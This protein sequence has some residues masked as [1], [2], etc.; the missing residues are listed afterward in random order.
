MASF[1]F[2][3]SFGSVDWKLIALGLVVVGILSALMFYNYG[4]VREMFQGGASENVFTMYYADWCPHC[5]DA[6][7]EFKK[8]VDTSPVTVGDKTC[9]IRMISSEENPEIMKAKGVKGFPTFQLETVDGKTVEYPGAR[10]TDGY[11][12]FINEHLGGGV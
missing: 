10:N 11:L 3:F 2:S 8:L 6:K 1:P 9:K 7:P 5:K 4:T 12:A